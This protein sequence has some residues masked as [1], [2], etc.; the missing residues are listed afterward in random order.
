MFPRLPLFISSDRRKDQPRAS[1]ICLKNKEVAYVGMLFAVDVLFAR[2]S[3]PVAR[4]P[5][6][7]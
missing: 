5:F 6:L 7:I 2:R 4:T 3:P 1:S